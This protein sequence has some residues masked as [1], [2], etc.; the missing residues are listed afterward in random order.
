MNTKIPNDMRALILAVDHSIE[1]E[2]YKHMEKIEH[3]RD[4][5]VRDTIIITVNNLFNR[6][7][8]YE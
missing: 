8:Y 5:Y 6:N 3:N 4:V 2:G 7:I 1:V